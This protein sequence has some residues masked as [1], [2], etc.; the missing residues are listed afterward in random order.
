MLKSYYK[1]NSSDKIIKVLE[2]IKLNEHKLK[3]IY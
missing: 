1:K 3:K 2:N